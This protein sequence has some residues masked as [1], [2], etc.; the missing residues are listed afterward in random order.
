MITS[1][2]FALLITFLFNRYADRQYKAESLLHVAKEGINPFLSSA[3]SVNFVYGGVNDKMSTLEAILT[4]RTHN[5][6]VIDA[7]DLL[8][9]YYQV[10]TIK[11]AEAYKKEVPFVVEY[12]QDHYQWVGQTFN[13]E[14][15]DDQ[16][17]KLHIKKIRNIGLYHLKSGE[18][19]LQNEDFIEK[20]AEKLQ[21]EGTYKFGQ[22]IKT[23]L[24]KFRLVFKSSKSYL[25]YLKNK[26]YQFVLN[27]KDELI[28]QM[29]KQI[30]TRDKDGSDEYPLASL[31]T[32]VMKG[33][34][35]NKIVDYINTSNKILTKNQLNQK[36]RVPENTVRF[37]ESKLSIIKDS[38]SKS[39][40]ELKGVRSS[41][42]IID[43][44]SQ[45]SN[46]L[47]SAVDLEMQ[48]ASVERQLEIL[49]LFKNHLQR[50]NYK[51]LISPSLADINDPALMENIKTIN[52]LYQEQQKLTEIYNPSVKPVQE[53]NR[54]ISLLKTQALSAVNS[55]VTGVRSQIHSLSTQLS[56]IDSQVRTLPSKE[57]KYVEA[58]R[59]YLINNQQYNQM[60]IKLNEALL[61]KQSNVSDIDIIDPAKNIGQPYISPRPMLNYAIGLLIGFFL[62][63]MYMFA[64]E[65]FDNKVK[66]ID[67][68][69]KY[70]KAPLIGTIGESSHD[71]NLVVLNKT[72]SG[73]AESFRAI[74]SNLKFIYDK[75]RSEKSSVD[76]ENPN[77]NRIILITSSISG[78]GK[79]FVSINL[80]SVFALSHRRTLLIGTDLR[81]PKIFSDFNIKNDVGLSN[82]LAGQATKEQIIQHT[83]I[84]HLDILTSGPVPPNPSELLLSEAL[85]KL[86]NNVRKEYKYVILD[87]PPV[88][89]VADAY[90]LMKF[91]D[92]NLYIIRNNYSYRDQFLF[93]DDKYRRGECP[94]LTFILNGYTRPN[95]G[96]GYG[97][98][99]FEEDS[100]MI[101][102]HW[103]YK[104][105]HYLGMK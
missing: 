46:A 18:T 31:I 100:N 75:D 97:Y 23:P 78:E 92:A 70:I 54:R 51:S 2:F 62:P 66:I 94:N 5:E 47:K 102:N 99:Y 77:Y 16:I 74:R 37:I 104:I 19:F 11:T 34:N 86:I 41:D 9:T 87:T 13:V 14:M 67:D 29:I 48:K 33:K 10:G 52:G 26:H 42:R 79:T 105:K 85:T 35:L 98:G 91:S 61:T 45:G 68:V 32:V 24:C 80:S 40:E 7:L 43:L 15:V 39:S 69:I 17:F 72:K 36:N 44:S 103:L 65:V 22:W 96:Y 56:R 58:Q 82:Y 81:K 71:N 50:G 53:I 8:T 4:S 21:E 73:I 28:N 76:I 49:L 1:I 63:M 84:P 3:T 59:L 27:V 90:E 64:V 25:Q 93:I 83:R 95:Y 6:K 88:G 55:Y 30:Q 57:Q 60:L 89:L 20:Y 38:M 12:D 101:K